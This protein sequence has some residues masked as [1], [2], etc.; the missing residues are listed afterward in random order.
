MTQTDF[1][2]NEIQES[3]FSNTLKSHLTKVLHND[4]FTRLKSEPISLNG[5]RF[6]VK[7]KYS[8]VAYF[9]SF[10][11]NA[12][13]LSENISH[14]LAE[15]F[16]SNRL[17]ELGF[18]AGKINHEYKHETWRL[19]TLESFGIYKDD[20][21]GLTLESSK[22]HEKVL[23]ELSKSK[24]ALKLIGGLLFLELFVVYEMK[25]LIKAFERDLP[26]LF[27]KDGYSYDRFPFNTQEYWYGHAL[28]D[29]WHFRSIEE[30]IITCI[31][32]QDQVESNL[33]SL[34]KGIEKVA[35]A[36][37][38]LYSNELFEKMKSLK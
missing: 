32:N 3:I 28:H 8:A 35:E 17:D 33:K 20:L 6:L 9:V 23:V 27:P 1:L 5:Y 12:E 31:G 24:D 37:N 19:R 38:Y 13:H 11:E 15:V 25:N 36:K 29:T 4:F 21:T 22:K 7:E 30:A 2:H 26:N 34:F 14:D 10:L 16:R 18:F